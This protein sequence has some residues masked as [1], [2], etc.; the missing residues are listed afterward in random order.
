MVLLNKSVVYCRAILLFLTHS[1]AFHGTA[2]C[3]ALFGCHSFI[4][5]SEDKSDGMCC[6]F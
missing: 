4:E 5:Q 3:V 6:T 2:S 1:A